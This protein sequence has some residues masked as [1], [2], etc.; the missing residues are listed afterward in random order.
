MIPS[1]N[2]R[3]AV[4]NGLLAEAQQLTIQA[5]RILEYVA[6]VREDPTPS[7]LSVSPVVESC[8]IKFTTDGYIAETEPCDT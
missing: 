3:I 4:A 1:N 5:S 7:E 6:S 2:E 8:D